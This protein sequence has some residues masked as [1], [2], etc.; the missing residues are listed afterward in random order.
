MNDY[1]KRFPD[2]K[3]G[4][5]LI[6]FDARCPA[7][8]REHIEKCTNALAGLDPAAVVELLDACKNLAIRNRNPGADVPGYTLAVA[9]TLIAARKLWPEKPNET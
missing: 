6:V 8:V 3:M 2:M 7:S 9:D 4:E 1:G 5:P